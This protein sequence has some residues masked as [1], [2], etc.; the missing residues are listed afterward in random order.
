MKCI[1]CDN[2]IPEERIEV[3]ERKGW[4]MRCVHCSKVETPAVFMNYGHKTA[5]EI[6]IVPNN[7]DGTRDPE[8]VRQAERA[9]RRSR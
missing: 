2:I 3:L 8:K 6:L 9:F 7:P 4:P 1:D 5:G